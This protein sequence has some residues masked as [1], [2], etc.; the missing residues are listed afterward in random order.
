[1]RRTHIAEVIKLNNKASPY[2]ESPRLNE[3]SQTKEHTA[4]GIENRYQKDEQQLESTG[5]DCPEHSSL[6]NAGGWPMPP[7]QGV[8]GVSK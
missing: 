8:I 4:L 3:N 2:L 7:P 1:M 5:K 6:E